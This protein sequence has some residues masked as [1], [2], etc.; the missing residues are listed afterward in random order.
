[1]RVLEVPPEI[2][3]CNPLCRAVI[4]TLVSQAQS[5]ADPHGV[6]LSDPFE[7]HHGSTSE[8]SRGKAPSKYTT[9]DPVTS[10]RM[11]LAGLSPQTLLC[12]SERYFGPTH[13]HAAYYGPLL[14][15]RR[16]VRG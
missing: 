3:N 15:A 11:R 7:V 9:P 12:N 2:L 13:D 14:P 8:A 1:M 5:R 6:R 16:L 10:M 4:A